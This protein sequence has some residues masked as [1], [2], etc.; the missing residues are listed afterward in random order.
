MLGW[1]GDNDWGGNPGFL[2]T[3]TTVCLS[4]PQLS[5]LFPLAEPPSSLFTTALSAISGWS[6]I[7]INANDVSQF[8]LNKQTTAATTK[9][10]TQQAGLN[11]AV[12]REGMVR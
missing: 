2:R 1:M 5:R 11:A 10:K 3:T 12:L 8:A 4:V 6:D 9:T 7:S